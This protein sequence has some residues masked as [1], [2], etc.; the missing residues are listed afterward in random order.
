MTFLEREDDYRAGLKQVDLDV[1]N[2]QC[3]AWNEYYPS[4]AP[5]QK[6][7]SGI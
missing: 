5:F 6:Q 4:N 2:K 3:E 7:D 1:L